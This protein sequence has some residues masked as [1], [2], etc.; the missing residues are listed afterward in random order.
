MDREIG[1]ERAD[2]PHE[3]SMPQRGKENAPITCA[4]CHKAPDDT[5]HHAERVTETA[6]DVGPALITEKGS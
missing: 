4:V 2:L 5:I 1:S 6:A 3:F